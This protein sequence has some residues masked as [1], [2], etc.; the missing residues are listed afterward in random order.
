M[1][2]LTLAGFRAH[3]ETVA[4]R[5]H[6]DE[7]AAIIRSEITVTPTYVSFSAGKDS[8]VVADLCHVVHPG[9]PILMVDPGCPYHWMEE[10]RERILADLHVREWNLRLFPFDKWATRTAGESEKAYR[11][12]IHA[13]MFVDLHRYAAEHGLMQRVT[14]IR[15]EESPARRALTATRGQSYDLQDGGRA[16]NPIARWRVADVWA[17]LVTRGLSWLSI[18]DHM[19]PAARNG[20]IGRN[21]LR[22]G[23]LAWL[24]IHYPTAYL[25]ALRV[26][27]A[28]DAATYG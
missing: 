23:R 3:A 18:Y 21:G 8:M 5:R 24:K 12:S 27:P 16:V 11:D 19:G 15:A 20:L 14:G 26:L 2:A 28:E 17:Y 7:S 6:V 22:H 25:E 1:D 10:E 13:E 9:I 4:F